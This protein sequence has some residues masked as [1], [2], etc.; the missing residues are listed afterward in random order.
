[1]YGKKVVWPRYLVHHRHYT[2][3]TCPVSLD[4]PITLA[5]SLVGGCGPMVGRAA[6]GLEERAAAWSELKSK[7]SLE[8]L[9]DDTSSRKALRS[10]EFTLEAN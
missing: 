10:L 7:L 1:M 2:L 8:L 9:Q 6:L 5:A 4:G 3:R